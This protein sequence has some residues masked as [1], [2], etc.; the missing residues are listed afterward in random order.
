VFVDIHH[1]KPRSEGGDHDPDTLAV[2]CCAH[3]RAIHRGQLVV[4]GRVSTGLCFRHADGTTYGY[5]AHPRAVA[6]FEEA[7]RGLRSLGFRE[8]EVRAALQYVNAHPN[9]HSGASSVS[10]VLRHALAWLAN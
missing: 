9:V 8:G 2:L 7:F 10:D 6:S 1:L 5:S 4:E 3:H